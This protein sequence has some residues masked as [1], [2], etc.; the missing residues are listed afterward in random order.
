[1]KEN[2]FLKIKSACGNETQVGLIKKAAFFE[3]Y[4][5]FFQNYY[6]RLNTRRMLD[7]ALQ[8]FTH[9]SKIRYLVPI[10]CLQVLGLKKKNE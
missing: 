6:L 4:V 9:R 8:F 3:E 5:F 10:P 2:F 7:T 1:M